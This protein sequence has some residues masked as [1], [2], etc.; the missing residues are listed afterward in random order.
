MPQ[1]HVPAFFVAGDSVAQ[2]R[3]AENETLSGWPQHLPSF[4]T[5]RLDVFNFAHDA[6]NAGNFLRDKAIH[7]LN[8]IRPGDLFLVAFGSTDQHVSRGDLYTSPEDYQDF[9]R[10]YVSLARERGAV[11]VIVTPVC[12]AEFAADGSV[13][14][15]S[16]GYPLYARAVAEQTG[17]PLLD[18]HR[19]TE[20]LWRRLGPEATRAYFRWYDAGESEETPRGRV[21][22]TNL[23]REGARRIAWLLAQET[24]RLGLVPEAALS[25]P[26]E[27]LDLGERPRPAEPAPDAP[28]P[29]EA[30]SNGIA[31]RS[32]RNGSFITA[33]ANFAGTAARGITRVVFVEDAAV[34][35]ST[36]VG[37]GGHWMWRRP[38]HWAGGQHRIGLYGLT[39]AEPTGRTALS[40]TVVDEVAAPRVTAPRPGRLTGPLPL[41]RGTATGARKVV[42]LVNGRWIGEAPVLAD[43]AWQ[44]QH[45]DPWPPG[46]HTLTFL[47]LFNEVRSPATT[48]RLHVAELD[49]LDSPL[50]PRP[51][52]LADAR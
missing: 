26:P 49:A 19:I 8:L 14:D 4:C 15:T 40:F 11:P 34:I 47:A 3:P 20:S 51:P 37:P 35:G 1:P 10:R 41:L 42:V 29:D 9:L 44:F 24:A 45:P 21:D 5:R 46:E 2:Q 28:L 52:S 32:V 31:S 43:G 12:Q 27:P 25:D 36:G 23:N 7:V 33:D 50:G 6:R 18:L 22:T 39:E 16:D 38:V 17:A 48:H 13:A 30:A